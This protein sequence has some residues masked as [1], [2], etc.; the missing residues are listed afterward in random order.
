M[1]KSTMIIEIVMHAALF[2]DR[3]YAIESENL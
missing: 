3:N 1:A 2:S